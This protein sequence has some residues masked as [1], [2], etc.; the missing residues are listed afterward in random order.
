MRVWGAGGALRISPGAARH[1]SMACASCSASLGAAVEV[2]LGALGSGQAVCDECVGIACDLGG[3]APTDLACVAPTP[4][5][6][7]HGESLLSGLGTSERSF[8]SEKAWAHQL[9]RTLQGGQRPRPPD[10]CGF[11]GC[12]PVLPQQSGGALGSLAACRGC[13]IHL[14]AVLAAMG[15]PVTLF[16]NDSWPVKDVMGAVAAARGRAVTTDPGEWLKVGDLLR[17]LGMKCEAADAYT[18]LG[19]H[20]EATGFALKAIAA[21]KEAMQ[22]WPSA[23]LEERVVALYRAVGVHL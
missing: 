12:R 23:G 16:P 3:I 4:R 20:F 6:A 18:M 15:R 10:G 11:C 13:V 17:S 14:A 2:I 9:R 1:L 19:E 21:Y 7:Q 8:R 22:L 5:E